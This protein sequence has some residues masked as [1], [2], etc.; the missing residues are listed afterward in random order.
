MATN[1]VFLPREFHGQR[2]PVGYSPWG[3]RESDMTQQLPPPPGCPVAR[4]HCQGPG[5]T[6]WLRN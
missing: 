5:F 4:I 6:P 2:N 3:H 1:S